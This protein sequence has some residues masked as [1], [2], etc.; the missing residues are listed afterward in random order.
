MEK[1]IA[2][3]L[4]AIAHPI[5]IKIVRIIFEHHSLSVSSIHTLLNIDQPIISLHLGLLRKQGIIIA[6][7]RGKNSYYSIVNRSIMQV[8]EIISNDFYSN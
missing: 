2:N 7:K 6:E 4:K 3:L 5:R 8:I 1:N